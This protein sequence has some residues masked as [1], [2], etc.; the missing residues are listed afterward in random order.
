MLETAIC[1][2]LP[3]PIK[4]HSNEIN[5]AYKEIEKQAEKELLNL[6]LLELRA[7]FEALIRHDKLPEEHIQIIKTADK[8]SAYVKCQTELKAGNGI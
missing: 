5:A 7:D 1:G 4:Y 8:I 6:L 3:I 2:D